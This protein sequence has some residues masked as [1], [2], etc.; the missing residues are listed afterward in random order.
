[1]ARGWHT[2]WLALMLLVAAAPGCGRGSSS[3]QAL[4]NASSQSG[5]NWQDEPLAIG[6]D[7]AAISARRPIRRYYVAHAADHC[8]IYWEENDI[9]SPAQELP[10]PR[11]IGP[12][13]RIRLTGRV[14]YRDTGDRERDV[15][16]RCPARLVAR[17]KAD[18]LDAGTP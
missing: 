14:C 3:E 5:T 10:C 9:R 8:A 13:E 6:P 7:G 4:A 17:E 1:M 12:G 15:P 2:T 11:E 18:R 16:V